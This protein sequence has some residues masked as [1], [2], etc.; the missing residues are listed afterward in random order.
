MD[1]ADSL[2]ICT[3]WFI[4]IRRSGRSL[5]CPSWGSGCLVGGL[6]RGAGP[7]PAGGRGC[8]GSIPPAG[9]A[10]S[11]PEIRA[12]GWNATLLSPA[13]CT[14]AG[15]GRRLCS[16]MPIKVFEGS[17]MKLLEG[18]W[19]LKMDAGIAGWLLQPRGARRCPWLGA[20]SGCSSSCMRNSPLC[21]FLWFS[22]E[23]TKG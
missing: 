3:A 13:L 2:L 14:G 18:G 4:F 1:T 21:G 10:T 7:A 16:W 6:T 11:T 20:D 22:K 19:A 5:A 17:Q 23:E 15:A 8:G 9:E 12:S